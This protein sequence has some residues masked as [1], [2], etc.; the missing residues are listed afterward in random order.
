MDKAVAA[1]E[2]LAMD[3][4]AVTVRA[5]RSLA[6]VTTAV[7]AQAARQWNEENPGGL[8][9]VPMPDLVRARVEALWAEAVSVARSEWVDARDFMEGKVAE[10]EAEVDSLSEDI[11]RLDAE[12]DSTR[13][14]L[15]EARKQV[16]GLETKLAAA[17][18]VSQEAQLRAEREIAAAGAQAAQV[19]GQLE[20]LREALAAK[21]AA[22]SDPVPASK[23]GRRAGSKPPL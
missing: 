4:Q 8:P 18:Q 10:A 12:L 21:N 6:R 13:F 22:L 19:Q 16:E 2:N 15:L 1:A 17:L 23:T 20:G 7:A 5:V 11:A 9:P 3:G 14:E